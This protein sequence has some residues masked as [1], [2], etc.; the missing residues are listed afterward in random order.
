MTEPAA[1]CFVAGMMFLIAAPACWVSWVAA[2]RFLERHDYS[3]QR[4]AAPRSWRPT[5]LERALVLSDLALAGFLGGLAF[6]L[7]G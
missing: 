6:A 7:N 5:R 3:S 4:P 2:W 1:A